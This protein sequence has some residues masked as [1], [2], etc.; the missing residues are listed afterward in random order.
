[1]YQDQ[2]KAFSHKSI[3]EVKA[4][5][6]KVKASNLLVRRIFLADGDVMTLSSR[7]LE[8]IL[9]AINE[10]F[11]D[12]QRISA[13]CLPRNLRN[14]TVGELKR[15][16]ELGL[17]LLYVGC[18]SGDDQILEFVN[19]GETYQSSLDALC[20]I[21][22]S[23]IKSSVMILNG[24]G[25]QKYTEQHAINSAKLMNETQPNYLSTLVVSFPL[26]MDRYKKNFP[27][28]L[29]L[30]QNHLFK[31]IHQFLTQLELK[32]TVFRSDH[33]SN[34][35]VLKGILN[36]DKDKLI[37]QVNLVIENP[38]KIQLRQEHQRGL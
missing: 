29:P 27:D 12:I 28:Y 32:K 35:L 3:T 36:R 15:L 34:Y 24:L 9:I 22:A 33:A 4:D 19:K 10:A 21:S 11:P 16:Q 20:K 26:G 30:E 1:M 18:E 38:S 6:A 2:Q 8:E 23:G 37:Q 13:Y 14:K 5:L 7:R 25:G 31:E 17:Q